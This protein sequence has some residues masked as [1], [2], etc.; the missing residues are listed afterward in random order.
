MANILLQKDPVWLESLLV[1]ATSGVIGLLSGD[2]YHVDVPA[3]LLLAA[4]PLIRTVLSTDHCPPAYVCPVISL[5]SVAG[6]VLQ[7]VG[8]ILETGMATVGVEKMM[9]VQ[10]TFKML[11]I[12]A[13]LIGLHYKNSSE[14]IFEHDLKLGTEVLKS[15]GNL[16]VDWNE[17]LATVKEETGFDDDHEQSIH[18]ENTN[19]RK[20][21]NNLN[22]VLTEISKSEECENLVTVKGETGIGEVEENNDYEETY[23][24]RNVE[25]N[26][27]NKDISEPNNEHNQTVRSVNILQCIECDKPLS[28]RCN[29]LRHIY[30]VTEI[31]YNCVQCPKKYKYRSHLLEHVRS[32]HELKRFKCHLCDKEFNYQSSVKKHVVAFHGDGSLTEFNCVQ[33]PKKYKYISHLLDHIRSIHELIRFKCPLCDKDFN[34]LSS[35]RRHTLASHNRVYSKIVKK[36]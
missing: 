9:E 1:S 15:T 8:T 3:V 35:V 23:N 20:E 27:L 34:S 19:A 32:V 18:E 26:H 36:V 11:K 16:D 24:A 13:G 6:D 17:N 2:G 25:F 14:S 21:F 22:T 31:S 29:L 10:E 30:R 12:E 4:S 7:L 28:K 5:P 33:C